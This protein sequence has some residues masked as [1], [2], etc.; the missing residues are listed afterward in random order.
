MILDD[1]LKD[2]VFINSLHLVAGF[3]DIN[4]YDLLALMSFQNTA[5]LFIL[6]SIWQILLI[7]AVFHLFLPDQLFL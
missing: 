7:Y 5:H 6:M 1:I 4:I 3:D 2:L